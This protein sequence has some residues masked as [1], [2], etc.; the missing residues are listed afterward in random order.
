[1]ALGRSDRRH[2]HHRVAKDTTLTV[3]ER[4]ELPDLDSGGR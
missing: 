4:L 1:M 3:L 2:H